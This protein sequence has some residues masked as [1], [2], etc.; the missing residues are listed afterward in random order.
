VILFEYFVPQLGGVGQGIIITAG[1]IIIRIMGNSAG[2]MM[3]RI[4]ISGYKL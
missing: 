4:V 2:L 3:K 1:I